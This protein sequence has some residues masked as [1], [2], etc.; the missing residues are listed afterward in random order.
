MTNQKQPLLLDHVDMRMVT[1]AL[2]DPATDRNAIVQLD[3]DHPG[4]R[5][6]EYRARRNQIARI[7]LEY[8]P[9]EPIPDAPY[10]AQEHE[11]WRIIW[12]AVEASHRMTPQEEVTVELERLGQSRPGHGRIGS[13]FGGRS[14]VRAQADQQTGR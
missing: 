8:K 12:E 10:T 9:G 2:S 1:T 5:D 13:G 7:A 14:S 11:V 6:G 3:P 4:F